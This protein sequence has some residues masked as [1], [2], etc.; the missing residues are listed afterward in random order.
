M[1]PFYLFK[2]GILKKEYRNTAAFLLQYLETK[3][4]T[5]INSLFP[6][7]IFFSSLKTVFP[8]GD[9]RGKETFKTPIL[10]FSFYVI[11]K[12]SLG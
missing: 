3:W 9:N 7:L 2:Y 4:A 8:L 6:K 1:I 5:Q 11:P 12:L 10:F